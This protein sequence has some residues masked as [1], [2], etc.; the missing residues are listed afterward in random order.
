VLGSP[1]RL[2]DTAATASGTAPACVVEHLDARYILHLS[3]PRRAAG[4]LPLHHP[5][6]QLARVRENVETDCNDLADKS[7]QLQRLMAVYSSSNRA[8]QTLA[9]SKPG[10][11]AGPRLA[12]RAPHADRALLRR[13]Q[14][15][16]VAARV[17][18]ATC[19]SSAAA[20][21]VQDTSPY[22]GP[23]PR[24]TDCCTGQPLMVPLTES[25]YVPAKLA[26]TENVL[27]DVGTGY[28]VQVRVCSACLPGDEADAPKP[29]PRHRAAR[30]HKPPAA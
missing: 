1:P 6:T 25:L 14:H 28:Y 17:G 11:P 19:T 26:D 22:L 18:L 7:V 16:S 4:P 2:R 24:R 21:A 12:R 8:V 29:L 5:L 20:A 13:R 15:A 9:E 23:T 30:P 10:A 3:T 27:V